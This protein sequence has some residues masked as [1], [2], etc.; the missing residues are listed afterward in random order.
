MPT[1]LLIATSW[2]M[3][4]LPDALNWALRV[5]SFYLESF[6]EDGVVMVGD[7]TIA[8][9]RITS[10]V[11]EKKRRLAYFCH[12]E[13]GGMVRHYDQQGNSPIG[14]KKPWTGRN[15]DT[16]MAWSLKK[17]K[18]A[19]WETW[20]LMLSHGRSISGTEQDD[21][22]L[23]YLERLITVAGIG[24]NTFEFDPNRPNM[25]ISDNG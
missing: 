12:E 7:T 4:T 10:L 25:G 2:R 9:D 17:S 1:I 5:V 20:G 21:G 13:N 19:G 23:D 22:D 18:A 8:D 14:S 15:V 3:H 16:A 11:M 24:G 6:P